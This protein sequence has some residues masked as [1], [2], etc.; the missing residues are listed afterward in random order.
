MEH[1]SL[2]HNVQRTSEDEPDALPENLRFNAFDFMCLIYS[3]IVYCADIGTDIYLCYEYSSSDEIAYFVLTLVFLL[4]PFL[5]I[6]GM[7][8]RW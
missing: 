8:L 3:I 6:L 5:A 4:V 2:Q 7:S 1:Y